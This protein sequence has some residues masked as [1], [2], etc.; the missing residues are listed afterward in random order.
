LS[1]AEKVCVVNVTARHQAKSPCIKRGT[2]VPED[3]GDLDRLSEE[4]DLGAINRV[5]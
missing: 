3:T 2:T 4:Q 1:I 5:S